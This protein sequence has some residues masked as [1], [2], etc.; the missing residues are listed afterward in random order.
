MAE[1]KSTLEKVMERAASMGRASQEE[2]QSEER[3]KE[4]M[5]MA[6]DYLQGK[7]VDFSGILEATGVSAL[8][9]KGLVQV[10]LRN[11]TLPRD[12][13][14]QRAEKAM[15]GLLELAKGSGDLVSVFR[16]MKG[17]L[18]H[19]QQHKKEI[20]QQVEDA[21]R[22]Q[23]EQALTQQTGQKGLGMKVDP[24]MHPKFQEEWSKVKADLD[25]QYNQ[26]LQQHKELVAQR[27]SVTL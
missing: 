21:F 12:D 27:F 9:K 2:I 15:Q 22:Q 18:E 1:I 8:V 26:V 17:I 4:G 6:A 25:G 3:V 23:M 13:E 7:E 20:H 11:I 16:D 19:Y 14:G 24:R 10:F 5:R